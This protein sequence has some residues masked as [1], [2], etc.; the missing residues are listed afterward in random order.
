[1]LLR[2]CMCALAALPGAMI[3]AA[4]PAWPGSN[5]GMSLCR[6]G[7]RNRWHS[8]VKRNHGDPTAGLVDSPAAPRGWLWRAGRRPSGAERC[9]GGAAAGVPRAWRRLHP[10]VPVAVQRRD[11]NRQGCG[12]HVG[13]SQ[14]AAESIITWMERDFQQQHAGFPAS[15]D[16]S[17]DQKR[18]ETAD[19]APTGLGRLR[20]RRPP[21]AFPEPAA[22]HQLAMR[23]LHVVRGGGAAQPMRNAQAVGSWAI[24]S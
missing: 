5:S 19:G 14:S 15:T 3:R 24:V 23:A 10:A 21:R 9:D 2:P 18:P 22:P 7:C 17:V 4:D 16:G 20:R 6:G 8:L 1:M 11:K 12:M 13:E